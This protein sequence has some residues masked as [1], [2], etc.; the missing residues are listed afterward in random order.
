MTATSEQPDGGP[1]SFAEALDW[2]WHRV[3]DKMMTYLFRYHVSK[4]PND[5]VRYW[6]MHEG[7]MPWPT[8]K[9]AFEAYK[10]DVKPGPLYKEPRWKP[11]FTV[12]EG[13]KNSA[14]S[15]VRGED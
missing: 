6:W 8:S 13:D 15:R 3:R 11:K 7:C 4:Y 12:I 14:P 10:A 5:L 1:R 9:L 2:E